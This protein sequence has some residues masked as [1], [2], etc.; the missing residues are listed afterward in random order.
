M[1]DEPSHWWDDTFE[2]PAS[3]SNEQQQIDRLFEND[4]KNRKLIDELRRDIGESN[5][6]LRRLKT[7]T[8]SLLTPILLGMIILFFQ[9]LERADGKWEKFG[10][11][12]A[13]AIG[14]W[15]LTNAGQ[16]FDRIDD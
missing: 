13:G 5:Q 9:E 14:L 15:W 16:D 6:R 1:A 2:T 7:A 11:F 4:R 3:R 12:I 10:V 8:T